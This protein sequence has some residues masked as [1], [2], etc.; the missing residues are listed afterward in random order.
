MELAGFPLPKKANGP[1]S[2]EKY[3]IDAAKAGIKLAERLKARPAS[4]EISY[5]A[6]NSAFPPVRQK[7]APMSWIGSAQNLP[8]RTTTNVQASIAILRML[9]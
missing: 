2:L 8:G 1:E 7:L 6:P 5:A 3:L 9:F 4:P